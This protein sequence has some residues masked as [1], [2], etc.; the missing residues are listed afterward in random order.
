MAAEKIKERL[1]RAT[2]ALDAAGVSSVTTL[3]AGAIERGASVL[4]TAHSG[5]EVSGLEFDVFELAHGRLMPH[6][7]QEKE[8]IRLSV[9]LR[10]LLGR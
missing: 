2:K 8:E 4:A 5:D 10:S 7:A 1:R 6:L 9:R 3:I